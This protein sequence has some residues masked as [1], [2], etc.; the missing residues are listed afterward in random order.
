MFTLDCD[1]AGRLSEKY[2]LPEKFEAY[3]L[4]VNQQPAQ[5]PKKEKVDN[6]QEPTLDQ[7]TKALTS[8]MYD[9]LLEKF[10]ITADAATQGSET[11]QQNIDATIT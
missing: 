4:T 3:H 10:R 8:S 6:A 5:K 2:G 1:T 9:Y 7:L 11:A